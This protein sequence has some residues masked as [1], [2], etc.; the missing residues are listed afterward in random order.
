[1]AYRQP[2]VGLALEVRLKNVLAQVFLERVLE[3]VALMVI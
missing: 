3:T 2:R 1:M